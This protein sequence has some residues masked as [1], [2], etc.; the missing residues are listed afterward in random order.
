MQ[1]QAPFPPNMQAQYG[2]NFVPE[3]AMMGQYIVQPDYGGM[4]NMLSYQQLQF[5]QQQQ[6]QQYPIMAQRQGPTFVVPNQQVVMHEP[7]IAQG[8]PSMQGMQFMIN[9]NLTINQQQQQQQ[10]NPQMLQAGGRYPGAQVMP[11]MQSMPMMRSDAAAGPAAMA[12]PAEAPVLDG[13]APQMHE[14]G[15][16]AV[17][18]VSES[19]R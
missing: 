8:N 19:K 7:I 9:P 16:R 18:K 2:M 1:Q 15:D 10:M 6:Q 13:A 3:Q 5:M 14:G 17:I 4:Q 11:I 12:V